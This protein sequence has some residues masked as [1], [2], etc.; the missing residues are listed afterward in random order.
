M[1]SKHATARRVAC[2]EKDDEGKGNMLLSGIESLW[3]H[4]VHQHGHCEFI[5]TTT[6]LNK[7]VHE[8]LSK[9]LI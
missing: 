8:N 2:Y 5:N 7:T 4:R 9:I 6:A 1:Q 3:L